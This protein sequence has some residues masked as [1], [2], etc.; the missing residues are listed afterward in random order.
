MALEAKDDQVKLNGTKDALEK[1]QDVL[2]S[3]VHC[4]KVWLQVAVVDCLVYIVRL[5]FG[6]LAGWGSNQ[7]GM[8]GWGV[9]QANIT[10]GKDW[11]TLK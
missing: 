4:K 10:Q 11:L 9:D 8:E 3:S 2:S 1:M 7:R 5:G 6:L